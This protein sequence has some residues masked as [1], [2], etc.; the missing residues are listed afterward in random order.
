MVA[1]TESVDAVMKPDIDKG[2]EEDVEF[3]G[4]RLK[5]NNPHLAALLNSDVTEEVRVI[6]RRARDVF[7]AEGG[8][9]D[10]D[11]SVDMDLSADDED[12]SLD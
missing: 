7:A 4:V 2:T 12:E 5:V 1:D 11:G 6:G 3:F 8:E 10:R 9:I